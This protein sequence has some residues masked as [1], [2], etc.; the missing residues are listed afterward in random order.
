MK[1]IPKE[2]RVVNIDKS[3]FDIIK[4]YCS[5][6]SLNMSKWIAQIAVQKIKISSEEKLELIADAIDNFTSKTGTKINL[7]TEEQIK[8][9]RNLIKEIACIIS[10]NDRK[11]ITMIEENQ[12]TDR[13]LGIMKSLAEKYGYDK[14]IRLTPE[15]NK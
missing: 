7:S 4:E 9:G 6:N 11:F 15:R 14:T 2:K 3:D 1:K 12:E 13:C 5:K 10:D 8:H